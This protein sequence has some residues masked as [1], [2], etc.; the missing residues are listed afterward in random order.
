MRPEVQKRDPWL[1]ILPDY[2]QRTRP[3]GEWLFL[4]LIP[5]IGTTVG[6]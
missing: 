2:W 1:E 3:D 6:A 5:A 4:G